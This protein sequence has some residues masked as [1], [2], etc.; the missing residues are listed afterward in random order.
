[1]PVSMDKAREFVYANGLLW[2]QALF[3]YLFDGGSL[4]RLHQCLLCYKNSDGGWGH[5]LEHDIK[6][7]DSHPLALEFLLTIERDTK[8]PLTD[9]LEG[10]VD[11]I[12]RNK[13]ED[14]SLKNPDSL[15]KYPHAP[16]WSNGGQSSP[17]S[18]TGNLIKMGICST[19]LAAS[20]SL[21][22]KTNLTLEKIRA[23]EWLFMAYHAHDYFLNLE[24]TP[25][26]RPFIEATIDNIIECAKN[27]TEKN[28]FTL[29]QFAN[30]PDTKIAKA[31]PKA[32]IN[33]FLDY[34]ESS[35]REDGGW[36]DEHGL[37][38]W[39]PYNTTFILSV[40]KNYGRLS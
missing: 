20:T 31:M 33:K 19:S 4:E 5:G 32:L 14:G 12:E 21:W 22:V 23:N 9:L 24:D 2:E 25:E 40:L 28:Y 36:N 16:W 11:W 38:H 3:S 34:L 18:I 8:I 39:Q 26:N 6:C 10:T 35:Q 1:M 15:H 37:K 17:D 27:A 7:P 13:N 30:S 29:F